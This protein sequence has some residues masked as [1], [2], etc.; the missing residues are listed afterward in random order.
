MNDP[1]NLRLFRKRKARDEKEQAAQTNRILHGRT[2]AE[3]D[4]T[5]ARNAKARHDHDVGKIERPG[6]K[7][8]EKQD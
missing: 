1:V 2:R 4:L 8:S 3:K 7:P 5:E 6:P